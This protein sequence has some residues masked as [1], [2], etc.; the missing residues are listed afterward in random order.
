MANRFQRGRNQGYA[1]G[2]RQLPQQFL[3]RPHRAPARQNDRH[4]VHI[5]L[6]ARVATGVAAEQEVCCS[7]E[8]A[9]AP[10]QKVPL[11]S[12]TRKLPT[13]VALDPTR[14]QALLHPSGPV[15]PAVG[16]A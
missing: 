1:P 11:H 10:T 12:H 4:L 5:P 16:P 13:E 15:L 2:L 6:A 8:G 9:L 14:D 3:Q 7:A